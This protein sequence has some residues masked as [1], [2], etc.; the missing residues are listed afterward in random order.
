MFGGNG[1]DNAA[2]GTLSWRIIR[3]RAMWTT[4]SMLSLMA[5]LGLVLLVG[6]LEWLG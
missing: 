3:E 1:H 5:S 2:A 4:A 6:A